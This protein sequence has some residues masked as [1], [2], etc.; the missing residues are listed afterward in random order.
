MKQA[1]S[2]LLKK[3]SYDAITFTGNL[4]YFP[5]VVAVCYFILDILPH[6]M[7]EIPEASFEA[8]GINPSRK[9]LNL[10]R[11]ACSGRNRGDSRSPF[12]SG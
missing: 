10:S 1:I 8:A 3:N 5:N 11:I 12:P 6:I 2:H 4:H 9:I 7:R